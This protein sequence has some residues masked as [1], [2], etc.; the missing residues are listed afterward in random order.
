MFTLTAFPNA[1]T[2]VSVSEDSKSGEVII[3]WDP[4][5][6]AAYYRIGWLSYSDYRALADQQ[7]D[8]QDGFRFVEV[9]NARQG[10]YTIT[11]L[12]P[13]ERYIFTVGSLQYRFSQANWSVFEEVT[14]SA[15]EDCP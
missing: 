5:A 8:W 15:A 13:D 7:R 6:D 14:L 12:N 4:V 10:S 1:P 9:T 2:N 11:G 3:N